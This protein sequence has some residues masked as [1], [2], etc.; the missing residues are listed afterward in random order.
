MIR[1]ADDIVILVKQYAEGNKRM[2]ERI[3]KTLKLKTN[4]KKTRITDAEKDMFDFLGFSFRRAVSPRKETK[5]AYFWPSKKS[6]KKVMEKVK[7]IT[8]ITRMEKVE[9]I[10][11]ELNLVIRGWTN[12]FRI[13]NG[14]K[15]LN[16]VKDY[17]ADKIRKYMKRKAGVKGYGYGK[18][19]EDYLY[20]KLGL[21]NDYRIKWMNA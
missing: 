19:T 1:Y 21:Y 13:S 18:Y 20:K 3:I 4:T 2:L 11:K 16:K 15:Q 6:V 7:T 17:T 8:S 9:D 12:Y 5:M 10:V 14:S